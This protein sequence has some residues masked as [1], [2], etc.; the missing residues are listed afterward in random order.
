MCVPAVALPCLPSPVS[1]LFVRL[2]NA[3]Q[4]VA[5]FISQAVPEEKFAG[6]GDRSSRNGVAFLKHPVPSFV[7]IC[8]YRFSRVC[9]LFG[10]I[11]VP[12]IL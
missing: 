7:N 8:G 4:E 3:R 2:V 9:L 6:D 1:I 11:K 10:G 12:F 5:I